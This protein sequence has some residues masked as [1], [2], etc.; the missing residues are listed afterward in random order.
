VI[1]AHRAISFTFEDVHYGRILEIL[2]EWMDLSLHMLLNIVVNFSTNTRISI[3][4]SSGESPSTITTTI[5]V[6]YLLND[7]SLKNSQ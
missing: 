4:K 3:L 2:W 7:K 6:I 1:V 5:I